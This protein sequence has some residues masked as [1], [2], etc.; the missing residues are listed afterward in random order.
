MM[1]KGLIKKGEYFD[2]VTLMLVSKEINQRK[3]IIDSAVVMGT[4]ENRAIMIAS[5][6]FLPEFERTL[7]NPLSYNLRFLYCSCRWFRSISIPITPSR[8]SPSMIGFAME[9]S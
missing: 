4:K 3:G 6:L 7:A 9:V 1:I 5:G 2:S 8:L